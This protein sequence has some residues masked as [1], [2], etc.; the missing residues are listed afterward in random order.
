MVIRLDLVTDVGRQ[1]AV[2][3]QSVREPRLGGGVVD[4][5]TR[6]ILA[7]ERLELGNQRG[8]Q[9]VVLRGKG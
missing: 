3:R 9:L 4:L 6:E 8:D 5:V 2:V 1:T 7:L